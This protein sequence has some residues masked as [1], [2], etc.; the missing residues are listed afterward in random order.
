MGDDWSNGFGVIA[1]GFAV[2]IRNLL[3][4]LAISA[5]ACASFV[6]RVGLFMMI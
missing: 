6:L 2:A 5:K 4:S 3:L 1:S